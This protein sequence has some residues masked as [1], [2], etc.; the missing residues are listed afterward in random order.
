MAVGASL[1]GITGGLGEGETGAAVVA[2]GVL[3]AIVEVGGGVGG[4]VAL[5]TTAGED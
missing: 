1:V 3:G 5:G 2:A 4:A